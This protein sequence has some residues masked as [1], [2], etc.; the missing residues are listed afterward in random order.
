MYTF[1]FVLCVPSVVY[2]LCII[3]MVCCSYSFIYACYVY[4]VLFLVCTSYESCT[5]CVVLC[6][7]LIK[8]YLGMALKVYPTY[9]SFHLICIFSSLYFVLPNF[10]LLRQVS[11]QPR[12]PWNCVPEFSIEL[13]IFLPLFPKCQ[14]Y[15]CMPSHQPHIAL[16]KTFKNKIYLFIVCMYL[17]TYMWSSE[18]NLEESVLSYNM[19]SGCGTQVIWLSGRGLYLLSHLISLQWFLKLFLGAPLH[20]YGYLCIR[21]FLFILYYLCSLVWTVLINPSS[22]ADSSSV[23]SNLLNSSEP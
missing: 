5:E 21:S 2:M 7:C 23:C 11:L 14:N 8:M 6:M 17:P 22:Y 4:A 18:D 9:S 16:L 15:R 13:L 1:A 10:L 20:P 3:F 12:L 19:D